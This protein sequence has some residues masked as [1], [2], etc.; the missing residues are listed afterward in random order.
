MIEIIKKILK[1]RVGQ[2]DIY[3][4][5]TRKDNSYVYV[6][7]RDRKILFT[8]TDDAIRYNTL[9]EEDGLSDLLKEIAQKLG[10]KYIEAEFPDNF[11]LGKKIRD[12]AGNWDPKALYPTDTK[13]SI[14]MPVE[15]IINQGIT[16]YGQEMARSLRAQQQNIVFDRMSVGDSTFPT[17]LR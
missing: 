1:T 17:L 8:S 10:R 11:L 2:E 14:V 3:V 4:C 6:I 12:S 16:A 9:F 5:T 7:D 15:S 13:D